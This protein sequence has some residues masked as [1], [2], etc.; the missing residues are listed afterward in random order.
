MSTSSDN[1]N[2]SNYDETTSTDKSSD[3]MKRSSS[4]LTTSQKESSSSLQNFSSCPHY[5]SNFPPDTVYAEKVKEWTIKI[6]I[7]L[8]FCPWA[9]KAHSRGLLRYVTCKGDTVN[10][11][12]QLLTKEATIL[13]GQQV[14]PWSS[15][16]IICPHVSAWKDFSVFVEFNLTGSL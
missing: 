9:G 5:F 13:T 7:Q 4:S 2:E 12:I 16:L 10:D 8:G 6:P 1:S 11:A 15:T 3:E 14:C